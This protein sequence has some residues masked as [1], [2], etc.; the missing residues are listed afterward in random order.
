MKSRD[1]GGVIRYEKKRGSRNDERGS[2]N[3]SS[4]IVRLSSL[5]PHPSSLRCCVQRESRSGRRRGGLA[6]DRRER[7]SVARTARIERKLQSVGERLMIARRQWQRG[8]HSWPACTVC[9]AWV[10]SLIL[11]R[12]RKPAR[13][14]SR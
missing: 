5:I 7:L 10:R 12:E 2:K 6:M 9:N 3:N 11:Y 14:P 4:F 13:P 8:A 1:E